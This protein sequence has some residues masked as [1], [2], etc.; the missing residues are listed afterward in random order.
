MSVKPCAH[1]PTINPKHTTIN[2]NPTDLHTLWLKHTQ[3]HVVFT[4]HHHHRLPNP[5][6]CEK[7][8][9]H[10]PIPTENPHH[11]NLSHTIHNRWHHSIPT[12]WPVTHERLLAILLQN[13]TPN[14]K[15]TSG[16]KQ[17][18]TYCY[19]CGKN[20]LQSVKYTINNFYLHHNIGKKLQ[21]WKLGSQS[22]SRQTQKNSQATHWILDNK[23]TPNNRGLVCNPNFWL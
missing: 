7:K 15:K 2:T 22:P 3:K 6:N 12:A 4:N 16:C 8:N 1:T 21:V 11:Q 9:S 17:F 5:P 10:D 13:L 18:F 20:E 14:P 19:L 23:L